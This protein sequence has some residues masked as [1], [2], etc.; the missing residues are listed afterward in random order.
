MKPRTLKITKPA[1]KLEKQLAQERMMASLKIE[2]E[3]DTD[4]VH[5]PNE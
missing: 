1:K 2:D 5:I 4:S 3:N